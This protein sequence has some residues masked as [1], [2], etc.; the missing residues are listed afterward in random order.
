MAEVKQILRMGIPVLILGIAALLLFAIRGCWAG[1]V[2][3]SHDHSTDDA[4]VRA[5]MTPLS[6]RVSGTVEAVDVND[7][8]QVTPG[9]L[10]VQLEDADYRARVEE[11]KAALAGARA[12]LANNQAQKRV[13]DARIES[14]ESGLAS[15]AAA[16]AAAQAGIAAIEPQ[17][18]QAVQERR[19]QE[20]L[21]GVRA[22][23]RQQV[24]QA[25][26]T[27]GRLAG[28]L[29]DSRANLAQA[30]ALL[31]NSRAALEAAKQQRAALDTTDGVY[32]ADIQ[33]KEAAI[34]VAEINLNYTKITA[35]TAGFVGVRHVLPG[36]LV[37]PGMEV[38]DLVQGQ[39]WI[40]AN[41]EETQLKNMCAGDPA[42]IRIDALPGATLHGK[43]VEIA[44]ASGSQFALLPPDN[45]TGNFTKIVQR[46]PVKIALDPGQSLA[47][48]LRAGFSA[49]VVI[50]TRGSASCDE[51][52]AEAP[53]S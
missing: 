39:D 34:T 22:A 44:P 35:P 36:Q 28:M 33:A 24:E 23:T 4:Y 14:A 40:E 12:Q 2:S 45:A 13:Q 41:Y 46:L 31:A 9:Q 32:E 1:W 49:V 16:V 26:A 15:G 8:Q 21:L 51:R 30:Q 19:R 11:A 29:G 42:T 17:L 52:A 43:V 3:E 25:V 18:T 53:R 47:S 37:T 5:D 7:Y 6:T 27:S 10:L 20:A 50:H 38:I 48:R